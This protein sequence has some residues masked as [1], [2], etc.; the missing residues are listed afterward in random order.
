MSFDKLP[1]ELKE[2]I[3]L[4]LD[5][6]AYTKLAKVSKEWRNC[7][8]CSKRIMQRMQKELDT[9][10]FFFIVWEI[11]GDPALRWTLLTAACVFPISTEEELVFLLQHGESDASQVGALKK[12]TGWEKLHSGS[13]YYSRYYN[14]KDTQDLIRTIKTKGIKGIYH[15]LS[16]HKDRGELSEGGPPLFSNAET[17]MK[18]LNGE[19]YVLSGVGLVGRQS[20][21]YVASKN[22]DAIKDEIEKYA[23][24]IYRG[25]KV[26]ETATFTR[27]LFEPR[28]SNRTGLVELSPVDFRNSFFCPSLLY[29]RNFL[30]KT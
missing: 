5:P 21:F 9:F 26:L 13:Q 20:I 4:T 19:H 30:D 3:A 12:T 14:S 22:Y 11:M 6:Y 24:L 1:L 29:F 15:Y 18:L 7:I 25:V 8:Y 16:T 10:Y 28:W 2:K 23:D 17:M 27:S